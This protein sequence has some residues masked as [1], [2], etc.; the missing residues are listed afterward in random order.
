M[1]DC[2]DD[3]R[4]FPELLIN[5]VRLMRRTGSRGGAFAQSNCG[6]RLGLAGRAQAGGLA[7]PA[8]VHGRAGNGIISAGRLGRG[9]RQW[10]CV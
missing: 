10:G 6:K 5:S 8:A 7:V 4:G 9:C 1:G 3:W 2:H